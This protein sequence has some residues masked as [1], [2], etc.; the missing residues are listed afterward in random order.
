MACKKLIHSEEFSG[1]IASMPKQWR[2]ERACH[3]GLEMMYV[4]R[5]LSVCIHQVKNKVLS[6]HH[7]EFRVPKKQVQEGFRHNS[8][9]WYSVNILLFAQHNIASAYLN[10]ACMLSEAKCPPYPSELTDEEKTTYL[11]MNEG[12][13]LY[14]A[15]RLLVTPD[16]KLEETSYRKALSLIELVF[17][18]IGHDINTHIAGCMACARRGYSM[19]PHF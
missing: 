12:D 7:T 11:S 13:I 2:M 17:E 1:Y 6:Q 19:I 8:S 3:D 5:I 4:G 16:G 15:F 9:I 10:I 14:Q 18:K